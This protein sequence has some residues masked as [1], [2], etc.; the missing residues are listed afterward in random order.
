VRNDSRLLPK[1]A[2][3]GTGYWGENLACN[4][5]RLQ[6]L[7]QGGNPES[8]VCAHA[9]ASRPETPMISMYT[10]LENS[11]FKVKAT[12]APAKTEDQ[13]LETGKYHD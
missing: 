4:F 1:V 12:N 10:K 11:R 8:G 9:G 3:I 5:A 2:V 6:P 7:S 13:K